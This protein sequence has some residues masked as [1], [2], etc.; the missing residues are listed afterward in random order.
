VKNLRLN[1]A[2]ALKTE[3]KS[4]L[5]HA[6]MQKAKVKSPMWDGCCQSCA[7][8][9]RIGECHGDCERAYSHC[10]EIKEERR[11]DHDRFIK[12]CRK[13]NETGVKD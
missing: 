10:T 6:S 3:K 7:K 13:C 5:I 4:F 2:W 11:K 8:W 9:H 1:P 12:E